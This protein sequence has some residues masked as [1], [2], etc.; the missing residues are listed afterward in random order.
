MSG[1]VAESRLQSVVKTF[2]YI[3]IYPNTSQH[4]LV[5]TAICDVSYDIEFNT[6]D[7]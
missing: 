3:Q 7:L 6:F 2:A 4:V 1:A 5:H